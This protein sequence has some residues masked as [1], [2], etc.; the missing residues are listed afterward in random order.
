LND[1]IKQGMFHHKKVVLNAYS[2]IS[3]VNRVNRRIRKLKL[4]IT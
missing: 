4:V 2:P 1:V 3:I